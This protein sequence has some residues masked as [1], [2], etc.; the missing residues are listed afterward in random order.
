M[1]YGRTPEAAYRRG[2]V[3]GKEAAL[4]EIGESMARWFEQY[5]GAV[6]TITDGRASL[7][8]SLLPAGPVPPRCDEL[9]ALAR[10]G[11]KA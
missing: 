3:D 5:P 7:K 8:H 2:H 11:E 4:R 9:A 10:L 6:V 1:L